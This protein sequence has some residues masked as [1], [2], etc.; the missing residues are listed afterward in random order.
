MKEFLRVFGFFGKE[1]STSS[2]LTSLWHSGHHLR[3]C[4]KWTSW[5]VINTEQKDTQTLVLN[6][7]QYKKNALIFVCPKR[8]ATCRYSV[9]QGHHQ[10]SSFIQL[11]R[12]WLTTHP[13]LHGESSRQRFTYLWNR[14]FHNKRVGSH[15]IV[16]DCPL[17][18]GFIA[19]TQGV[20][21]LPEMEGLCASQQSLMA[22]KK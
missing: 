10:I 7:L 20:T 13:F 11:G 4:N 9:M 18:H 21:V 16:L 2:V 5:Y 12:T 8:S 1:L 17:L 6:D 19:A 14:L 3:A 15:V 22:S